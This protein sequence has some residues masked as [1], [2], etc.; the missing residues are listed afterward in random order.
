M[1]NSLN[2]NFQR[3]TSWFVYFQGLRQTLAGRRL[4]GFQLR[5]KRKVMEGLT[6]MR[7]LFLQCSSVWLDWTGTGSNYTCKGKE[8]IM[9]ISGKHKEKSMTGLPS[10]TTCLLRSLF[11]YWL[12]CAHSIHKHCIYFVH[13]QPDMKLQPN[14]MFEVIIIKERELA[15]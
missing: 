8:N 7:P 1:Y 15:Y 2:V 10:L 13:S 3:F 6:L 12:F 11:L 9:Y 5:R 4:T 14:F